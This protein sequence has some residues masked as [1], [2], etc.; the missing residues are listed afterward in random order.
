MQRLV[1][2]SAAKTASRD[3]LAYGELMVT[4]LGLTQLTK[5]F[6]IATGYAEP[7]PEPYQYQPKTDKPAQ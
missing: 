2:M 1:W 6:D 7:D 3:D 5:Q 4:K